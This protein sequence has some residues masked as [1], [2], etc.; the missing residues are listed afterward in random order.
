MISWPPFNYY[1]YYLRESVSLFVNNTEQ[2][3]AKP[4]EFEHL[5]LMTICLRQSLMC[6]YSSSRG[7]YKDD[8]LIVYSTSFFCATALQNVRKSSSYYHKIVYCTLLAGFM[9]FWRVLFWSYFTIHVCAN[10]PLLDNNY[11]LSSS[12]WLVYKLTMNF[13]NNQLSPFFSQITIPLMD[14]INQDRFLEKITILI[15]SS[16]CSYR[17]VLINLWN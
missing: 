13:I 1:Y 10:A 4:V 5:W 2:S 3:W 12:I 17:S 16:L 11:N 7:R 9:F 14:G 8:E 15:S 6:C